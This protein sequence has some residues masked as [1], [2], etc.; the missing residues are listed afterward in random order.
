MIR[1]KEHG[2]VLVIVLWVLAIL[3][4]I[5]GGFAYRSKLDVRAAAYGMDR[6]LALM[7]ARGAVH[8][9]LVELRNKPF[10]DLLKK[11]EVGTTHLGQPWAK[12]TE[13]Y[14]EYY[15]DSVEFANDTAGFIIEDLGRYISVNH[16]SEELL[17]GVKSMS[18]SARRKIISRREKGDQDGE[19]PVSFHA[20]EEIR[21]LRAVKEDDWF[22][23][24]RDTGLRK[25]LTTLGDGR[26]NINTASREVL[27]CVPKLSGSAINAIID[28]R[29]DEEEPPLD[30][31]IAPLD[32]SVPPARKGFKDMQHAGKVTGVSADNLSTYCKVNSQYFKI[33]GIAT[34]RQGRI[35][36]EVVALVHVPQ[37]DLNVRVL[38]WREV[39]DG[40]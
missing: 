30:D 9:G 35:R 6:D 33:R 13:L 21:Y 11:N 24:R 25:L 5:V 2:F 37:W 8:R 20:I 10:Y 26:V 23:S 16:A 15:T 12:K 22:G 34:R 14:G 29:G 32:A 17:K 19:P 40:S 18:Q 7:M 27:E 31:S 36:A 28:Y 38:S 1:K 39:S 3:T 4:V